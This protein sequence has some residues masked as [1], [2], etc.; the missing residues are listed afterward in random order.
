MLVSMNYNRDV[1]TE[2]ISQEDAN[3]IGK[4]IFK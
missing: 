4:E 3:E 1:V 2:V